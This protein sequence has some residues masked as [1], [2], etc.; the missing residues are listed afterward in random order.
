MSVVHEQVVW[1]DEASPFTGPQVKALL[2]ENE[3]ARALLARCHALLEMADRQPKKL[4][5]EIAAHLGWAQESLP[6]PGEEQGK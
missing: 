2:D 6:L 5:T 3:K 1:A 4:L